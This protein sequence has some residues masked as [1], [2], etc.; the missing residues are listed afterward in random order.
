MRLN[1]LGA[2]D[3]ATFVPLNKIEPAQPKNESKPVQKPP[4][5]PKKGTAFIPISSAIS[6]PNSKK[7]SSSNEPRN[8]TANH[9]TMHGTRSNATL[10]ANLTK[11]KVVGMEPTLPTIRDPSVTT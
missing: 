5:I 9:T 1:G 8:T 6:K 2:P 3:W 4:R 11:R 10:A 7:E